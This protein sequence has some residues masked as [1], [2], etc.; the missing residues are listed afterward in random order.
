MKAKSVAKKWLEKN[1]FRVDRVDNTAVPLRRFD[2][3][4]FHRPIPLPINL[5][6][7]QREPA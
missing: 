5:S 1:S 7:N 4:C 2:I 6:A 3:Q